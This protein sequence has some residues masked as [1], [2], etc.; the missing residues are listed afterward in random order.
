MEQPGS[1]Y[2]VATNLFKP[3][4]QLAAVAGLFA[5]TLMYLQ[6]DPLA[7][8]YPGFAGMNFPGL[9]GNMLFKILSQTCDWVSSYRIYIAT[10]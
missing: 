5:P 4:L 1:Q 7:M 10:I 8:S 3:G 2:F 6:D 9:Y